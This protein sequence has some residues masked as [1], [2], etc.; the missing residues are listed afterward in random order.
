MHARGAAADGSDDSS[1][2]MPQEHRSA[3]GRPSQRR[4]LLCRRVRCARTR[5]QVFS[6]NA[7]A[8]SL[9][10]MRTDGRNYMEVALDAATNRTGDV[11]HIQLSRLKVCGAA[12]AARRCAGAAPVVAPASGH[13]APRLC[14]PD[15]CGA[16]AARR[17]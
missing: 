3:A 7:T 2:S 8:M 15:S 1:V 17:L 16:A 11:W 12:A 10:L 6:R 4:G 9:C 13:C 14:A 5:A